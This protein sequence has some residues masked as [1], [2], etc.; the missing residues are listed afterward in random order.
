M[1]RKDLRKE[2]SRYLTGIFAAAV[3]LGE[4]LFGS[5]GYAEE[6]ESGEGVETAGGGI[7]VEA[8]DKIKAPTQ[9]II[10]TREG[11]RRFPTVGGPA[12]AKLREMQE[13]AAK[14]AERQGVSREKIEKRRA[15]AGGE[16]GVEPP[17]KREGGGERKAE[18]EKR[19]G[20]SGDEVT[21]TRT[22][23]ITKER[24]DEIDL[25]RASGASLRVT[26]KDAEILE[27]IQTVSEATK[28]NFIIPQNLKKA[29]VT[30]LSPSPITPEELWTAFLSVLEV[31]ELALVPAGKYYKVV[32]TRDSV[33]S[34]IPLYSGQDAVIPEN[35]QI[36]TW[37]YRL[38]YVDG[39]TIIPTLKAL[40]SARGGQVLAYNPTNT[41]I[42]SDAAA[43]LNKIKEVIKQLDVA[44]GGED[45]FL[46]EIKYATAQEISDKISQVF[47]VQKTAGRQP[48]RVAGK[49]AAEGGLEEEVATISKIIPDERT[50]K[51]I[52]IANE[53]SFQK[54][55][56]LIA[57]LDVPVEG[58]GQIHVHYLSFA[59]AEKVS[60]TL[61]QLAQGQRRITPRGG[62][63]PAT[64]GATG[65]L[66]EGEIK[67]TADKPTNSLV[68]VA[69]QGDYKN[70][71]TIID[72][73]DIQRRQ[74]YV[75]AVIMEVG[76][77]R[78]LQTGLAFNAG[79]IQEIK[80][81]EVPIFF[82]TNYGTLNS[83]MV[84]PTSLASLLGFIGGMRGPEV[85]GSKATFGV[86]LP[87]FGALLQAL[88]TN[89][90]ANVLSTPH[91]LTTDNEEAT[92]IVGENVPFQSGFTTS[93]GGGPSAGGIFQSFN[94]IVSI[95]RQDVALTLKV[96]PQ[97]NA[98]ESLSLT[99]EQ[100]VSDIARESPI[101][102]PTT[103]K[104]SAKTVVTIKDQQTVVIGGLI[105][106]RSVMTDTKIPFL[107]DIPILGWLFR[108][109]DRKSTKTNLLL[110]LTPYIIRSQDDF[111]QIFERKMRER[112]EFIENFYGGEK[113]D[114]EAYY[115]FARVKGPISSIKSSINREM[116]KA[117]NGGPGIDGEILIQPGEENGSHTEERIEGGG[118]VKGAG[119]NGGEEPPSLAPNGG[120]I[121][122]D[123]PR[124]QIN[125]PTEQE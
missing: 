84:D 30:M 103:N 63:A 116:Q 113:L 93:F 64:P 37:L 111:R 102:G 92:I 88:K 15:Q 120:A 22:E 51:I 10:K 49:K 28:K 85:E 19:G 6:E 4:L 43:N 32:N 2:G 45:V 11:V 76:L 21:H 70:L 107:G 119:E 82:G 29:K 68:I 125:P 114:Y 36:V 91:I 75:E 59:D 118:I 31:N 52:I 48:T 100:E 79:T 83:V 66:F 72:K 65:E 16:G 112:Q 25:S 94:P 47:D 117:E 74:V 80:G 115:D 81:E 87:S 106:S 69:S 78:Q 9:K 57:K 55:K 24:R 101:L 38:E 108:S 96:K 13:A 89:S 7:L 18:S 12:G 110:L 122:V 42:I 44:S 23:K 124:F 109:S 53:R 121:D 27:L 39:N 5:F 58:A 77:D 97:I 41:L 3:I 104:R 90:D 71:K 1:N 50:N 95:Q 40:T 98:A 34:T 73:L 17:P 35:D 62:K 60:Q 105:R 14:R 54:V 26:F 99:I 123:R 86:G 56:A 46:I 67:I 20:E 61:S 33:Q 8:G